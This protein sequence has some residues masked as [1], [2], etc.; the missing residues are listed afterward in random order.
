MVELTT[1]NDL[2]GTSPSWSWN[3]GLAGLI[4]GRRNI[5]RQRSSIVRPADSLIE[6]FIHDVCKA[7][8]S[9]TVRLADLLIKSFSHGVRKGSGN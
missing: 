7:P 9:S 2:T 3:S 5:M 6:S 4:R 1:L 8:R